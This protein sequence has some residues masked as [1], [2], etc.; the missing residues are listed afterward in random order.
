MSEKTFSPSAVREWYAKARCKGIFRYHTITLGKIVLSVLA[1]MLVSELLPIIITLVFRPGFPYESNGISANFALT[2]TL[3]FVCAC[4]VAGYSTRFLLRFGTSRFSVWLCN[5]LSLTVTACALLLASL[6]VSILMGYLM[7][8]LSGQHPSLFVLRPVQSISGLFLPGADRAAV[9]GYAL[10]TATLAE[11]FK[12]LPTL[13][14]WSAEWVSLFY[15]FGCC[16]RRWK[17]ITIAVVVGLPLA[18]VMMTVVPVLRE[19]ISTAVNATD[20]EMTMMGL[21]WMRWIGQIARFMNE[22]WQWIQLGAAVL[23]LP[24]SYWCMRGTKQP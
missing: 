3:S 7:L 13:F 19:T 14:L 4:R 9:D 22:Q 23:A 1:V 6:A 20:S 18:L 8:W 10:L 11:T 5:I 24:L 16:L 21:Q 2:A 12:T 17:K 15:L